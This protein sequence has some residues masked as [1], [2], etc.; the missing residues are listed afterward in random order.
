MSANRKDQEQKI[1][2]FSYKND[3]QL[4]KCVSQLRP[5]EQRLNKE[6]VDDKV[7]EIDAPTDGEKHEKYFITFPYP[8][9]N[10]R[11][12]LG[13]MFTFSKAEF[14]ARYQRMKG[15]YVLFP[16]GFHCTGM[17][18]KASADKLALELETGKAIT[19]KGTHAKTAAKT[20]TG[21]SQFD[22]LRHLGVPEDE[23]PQ[24]KDPLKWL[25]YFPPI[26]KEDL[27][28]YGSAIDWRRS[29]ITTSFNPYYDH[30]V[31]WQ[32]NILKRKG[33]ITF[34]KRPTI[35]SI[36]DQQPCLDHDRHSG[37]GVQPQEY[38]LIKL[39][40]VDPHSIDERFDS[41][42]QVYLL[43]ATLRPETMI[44]QTNYWVKPNVKYEVCKSIDGVS[45]YITGKRSL[46]NLAAQNLVESSE[47]LY[48][49]ESQKL[50]GAL[51][52]HPSIPHQIRGLPLLDIQ[53][54][55]GTGIV[56]SVPTD[57]PHDYQGI[58]D[59]QKNKEFR[60]KYNVKPEWLN[61]DPI[62]IIHTEKYGDY[63]AKTILDQMK[64]L[65]ASKS[66]KLDKAKALAY[67]EG[68]YHGTMIIG[69]FKGEKVIVA[70][71]KMKKLMVDEN[72]ALTYYEPEKE[73]I[74][75]SGD[76]CVVMFVDQ[77]YIEYGK[78]E[79]KQK[80]VEYFKEHVQC[81]HDETRE[82]FLATFEWLG[83]WAC[84]RQFGLGTKL[85][86]S[87]E[88]LIDSLSDSTI[89][90]SYYTIAHL[91]QGSLNGDQPGLAHLSPEQVNDA[92]FDCVFLNGPVPEGID[93]SICDR[94]RN[95]FNFWY[96]V[97]CRV[98]GKDLVTNHLTMYL[99]NHAAIFPQDK[100]PIGI[101]A[102]G[103]LKLNNEKMSK[104]TG[105]FLT[106]A[107]A[108]ELFSVTGVRIGLADAG[109]GAD[110]A[111]FDVSVIKSSLLRLSAFKKF[112]QETVNNTG[113]GNQQVHE[114]IDGFQ[115]E[116]FD[117]K[118]S[119]I[120]EEVNSSYMKLKFRNALKCAFFDL[121]NSW[122]EYI[123]KTNA[124]GIST[125]LRQKYI[126]TFLVLLTPIIP[127]YTDYIWRDILGK[128]STIINE[129][130]PEPYPYNPNLFFMDRLIRK[131]SDTFRFRVK[132]LKKVK[133]LNK[134][135]IF[136]RSKFNEIQLHVLK[137]L[138]ENYDVK[139]NKWNA[140]LNNIVNNDEFLNNVKK[141]S[142]NAAQK[143][144]PFLKFLQDSVPEFGTFL[145][146]DIPEIDQVQLF[147]DNATFFLRQLQGIDS[148]E[149]IDVDSMKIDLPLWDEQLVNAAQV[150][151]PTANLA[152]VD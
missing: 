14:E 3:E 109:D 51:V 37:E 108:I 85:P 16:F 73:V 26:G 35:Y 97:D 72:S 22:I 63:A 89:Y 50:I 137:I 58:I 127:H 57:A 29:F 140:D 112:V 103:H 34:G 24:F 141:E 98:S 115:D 46:K 64:S 122:M 42:S 43:A 61:I 88:F 27:I 100:W 107:E 12:H 106:S 133:G 138:R 54:N 99:Y 81:F 44:G 76:E 139:E 111:N 96:P 110:A 148:I 65:S 84:S 67:K 11:L 95:E 150:Y 90:N 7:F 121:Q 36:K 53:M 131:L 149:V 105:N 119:K 135:C 129:K 132:A 17:P 33:L 152:K 86:F 75:R 71:E 128:P 142:K 39:K 134:A 94:C 45:F 40:L 55:K 92:F 47:S 80:V 145:L 49:I 19:S 120:I 123:S 10:G 151:I 1:D 114:G 62:Y 66:E 15:K 82:K 117:A 30:F 32:F 124:K 52:S 59:L 102:N 31:V 6:W 113:K 144:M 77:W 60:E 4:S 126:E 41:S 48:Q 79:W 5:I 118:L 74:S 78:E 9:M 56:T 21:A 93:K 2:L 18:I 70:K 20:E 8:Y 69:P 28:D 125:T 101:R 68:F 146:N 13:H 83:P 104:S 87:Q 116:L 147:K 23:I 143:F 38:T 136:V 130:M 25:V 91:L